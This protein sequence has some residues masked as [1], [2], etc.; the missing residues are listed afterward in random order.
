V[1]SATVRAAVEVELYDPSRRLL[2]AA[3]GFCSSYVVFPEGTARHPLRNDI[4]P[5]QGGVSDLRVVADF[6]RGLAF[7]VEPTVAPY[8]VRV[9]PWSS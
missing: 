5:R 6:A 3:S 1:Q 9:P 2:G 4:R 8:A 7:I